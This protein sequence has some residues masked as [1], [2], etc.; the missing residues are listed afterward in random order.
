MYKRKKVKNELSLE[1]RK[2]GQGAVRKER[3]KEN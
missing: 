1:E 3:K 2:E